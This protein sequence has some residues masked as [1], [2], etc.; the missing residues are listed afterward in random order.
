MH[1]FT[2]VTFKLLDLFVIF[3][4]VFGSPMSALAAPLAQDPAP[5]LTTDAADYALGE[6]AGITGSGFATGEYVLT[7]SGPDGSADW[8]TVT[9]GVAGD[10][11]ANSPQLTSAGSYEVSA[12]TAGNETAVASASFTVTAPP[13]PTEPPTE[14]PTATEP[15]TAE[16]TVAPTDTAT[17]EP[18]VAPTD[19]PTSEPT[20]LLTPFIQ[21]DKAD[22]APGELVTL[23]GGN[24]QGDTTVVITV[25]DAVPTVYHDTDQVQVQADGMI[26]D[27]FNLPTTFVDV[28]FVT[29]R[30]AQTGRVATTMFTDAPALTL[31][32]SASTL[33][34]TAA[35]QT[36]TYTYSLSNT[37]TTNLNLPF[38][39]TDN[40]VATV[41]CPNVNTVGNLNG[42]LD[43]GETLTCT[44]TY[45]ITAANVSF[46]YVAN[47]ATASSSNPGATSSN[48]DTRIV[49][50]PVTCRNDSD[51]AN[52]VPGQK[53]L[54][55]ECE[56]PSSV[57]PLVI[58]WNWDVISQPGGNSA[59]ACA[60]FDT[61]ND[62]LANYA[63]CASWQ[64]SR[65]MQ[66]GYPQLYSCGDTRSDR[67]TGSTPLTI[68]NGSACALELASDDPF[69]AGDSFPQD[70]KAFCSI[71]LADVGGAQISSLIDV[72]SYPSAI[73]NWKSSRVWSRMT[74]AQ[75]GTLV[76]PGTRPSAQRLQA[77]AIQVSRRLLL[78]L[79]TSARPPD[80]APT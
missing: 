4:M 3:T 43:P 40:K 62:G 11:T 10:F 57:N 26:T 76:G 16:P 25:V 46:G 41:T 49:S 34:Y 75:T 66:S 68:T 52:D 28:Y 54:T 53:D 72:C 2:K 21:S 51:G 27:S 30:G 69:S 37:G 70:T 12:Y 48:P 5:A 73:P 29:A 59:D 33:T 20:A 78:V 56:A 18:T 13:A 74:P 8:G 61:D 67:C 79:I 64:N 39:V 32:K 9:A 35:G 22:Y 7:A 1:K 45:T 77:A 71:N 23:T 80:Q 31:T 6:S 24:W 17:S 47:T 42:T 65:V 60:L 44:G 36:I 58:S 50:I 55:Q 15:P 19:T 14:S 38:P 63:L